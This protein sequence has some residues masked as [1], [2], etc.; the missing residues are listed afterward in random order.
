MQ[1]VFDFVQGLIGDEECE[2]IIYA[3]PSIWSWVQ[4][5]VPEDIGNSD[6]EFRKCYCNMQGFE[7]NDYN[8]KSTVT[9]FGYKRHIAR[10]LI[11][12]LVKY[13]FPQVAVKASIDTTP[14]DILEKMNLPYIGGDEA[15]RLV[16]QILL[17]HKGEPRKVLKNKIKAA[18]GIE[19]ARKYPHWVQE[20]EW[21]FHD[22]RPMRFVGETREGE[23]FSYHFVDDVSGTKTTV[24]QYS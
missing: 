22:N 10:S 14:E 11:S 6:C 4:E 19:N 7:T 9:A 24:E 23:L 16:R 2:Y 1:V 3:T 21:P 18:F 8:V 15:E 5:L 20:P 12:A 13:R 17:D